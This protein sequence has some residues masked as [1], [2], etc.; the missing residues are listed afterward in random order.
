MERPSDEP[1]APANEA[2]S[3]ADEFNERRSQAI[4]A[5]AQEIEKVGMI[6]LICI[7][8]TFLMIRL[9]S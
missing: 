5:K 7:F 1:L 9:I 8:S 6:C 4:A 3:I 2:T